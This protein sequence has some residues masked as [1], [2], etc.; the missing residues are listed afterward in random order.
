MD[1]RKK[2]SRVSIDDPFGMLGIA[3]ITGI[4]SA[5]G[6]LEEFMA[7]CEMPAPPLAGAG[8]AT[9]VDPVA[10]PDS[11]T[12]CGGKLHPSVGGFELIC[13]GCGRV[14]PVVDVDCDGAERSAPV[15]SRLRIVGANSR[16][17]QPNLHSSDCHNAAVSQK[18]QLEKE[19]LEYR[20]R[21]IE[22]GGKPF[23]MDACLLAA[24]FYSMV[25]SKCVRRSENKKAI[26]AACLSI[27]CNIKGYAP[28]RAEIAAFMQLTSSGIAKG[29]NTIRALEA[30]GSLDFKVNVDPLPAEITTIFASLGMEDRA[31]D[32]LRKAVADI[33][34]TAIKN[35]IGINSVLR[36]K[37]A[38]ATFEV[39]RRCTD[40]TL[41]PRPPSLG[42]F[43]VDK[44]RKATRI[45]KNTVER[46]TEMLSGYHTYFVGCYEAAGLDTSPPSA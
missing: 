4:E 7:R 32:G 30:E 9:A 27:A 28:S 5:M 29:Y 3:G 39:L 42:E 2:K 23:P 17:Y 37:V 12:L 46:F 33:V 41:V 40:R 18:A 19:F 36:S 44:P 11:C 31:Y 38:G 26:M 21:Y 15:A 16:Q 13:E 22:A 34:D 10:G 14:V 20:D 43:C 24:Q 6:A 8:G 1:S 45:R 35:H 25:Q